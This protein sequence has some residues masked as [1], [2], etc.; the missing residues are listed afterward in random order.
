M[1]HMSVVNSSD[2][3]ITMSEFR[4]I[5]PKYRNYLSSFILISVH[6]N[7][8][9]YRER[10][11]VFYLRVKF[12]LANLSSSCDL[13]VAEKI[14]TVAQKK[15][16]FR[17]YDKKGQPRTGAGNWGSRSQRSLFYVRNIPIPPFPGLQN[18]PE[19]TFS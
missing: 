16:M 3:V 14:F 7:S 2:W 5:K 8:S 4:S 19:R 12:K 17:L 10:P 18:T 15:P 6:A 9:K 1:L 13:Y 11:C